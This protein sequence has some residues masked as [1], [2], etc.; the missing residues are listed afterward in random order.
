MAHGYERCVRI[1][2]SSNIDDCGAYGK[3]STKFH[4]W[5]K[6]VGKTIEKNWKIGDAIFWDANVRVEVR[7]RLCKWESWQFH[8]S[9]CRL[10]IHL[11]FISTNLFC[12]LCCNVSVII[13][14]TLK[15]FH[16]TLS[17]R[18]NHQ[19]KIAWCCTQAQKLRQKESNR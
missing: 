9:I 4:I 12:C 1:F 15:R 7:H 13:H 11:W 5:L 14:R 10:R 8:L 2:F 17:L 6:Q 3:Y 16:Q 18:K 19:I